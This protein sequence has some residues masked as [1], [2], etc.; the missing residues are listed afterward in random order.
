VQSVKGIAVSRNSDRCNA[1]E[2]SDASRG[3]GVPGRCCLPAA[4]RSGEGHTRPG[5]EK[6]VN[7]ISA[8]E[9]AVTGYPFP[10]PIA[11]CA[12]AETSQP[13][14]PPGNPPALSRPMQ[15]NQKA[16]IKKSCSY[17]RPYVAS[18]SEFRRRRADA[19]ASKH[20]LCTGEIRGLDG[21]AP[22]GSLPIREDH[23]YAYRPS[24]QPAAFR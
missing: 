4:F 13:A 5:L 18:T 1:Q 10:R 7:A 6:L 9:N 3:I 15:I 21:N 19:L 20:E 16:S 2:R 11:Y 22:K 12:Q 17:V 23:I 24:I 8:E 14:S